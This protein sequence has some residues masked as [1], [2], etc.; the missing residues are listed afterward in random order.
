[1]IHLILGKPG[2]GKTM[3]A[4]RE[5]CNELAKGNRGVVTNMPVRLQPWVNGAGRPM[6]G[7]IEYMRR[8]G[9]EP[10]EVLRRIRLIPDD[11]GGTFYLRR[12][13]Y[14]VQPLHGKDGVSIESFDGSE[15]KD[16]VVYF[17]DECWRFFGARDWA[18][19][20]KALLFYNA[21]HRKFS[22]EVF[23]ITQ[24]W[25]QLETQIRQVV[26]DYWTCRNYGNEVLGYFRRK[27]E[28]CVRV[29]GEPPAASGSFAFSTEKFALDEMIGQT[30]D[31]SGGVGVGASR[32]ADMLQRKKGLPWNLIY[33]GAFGV[34]VLICCVGYF[35]NIGF[36]R[37]LSKSPESAVVVVSPA[38]VLAASPG[39]AVVPSV[40]PLE[41]QASEPPVAPVVLSPQA[42]FNSAARSRGLPPLPVDRS[43]Y[44]TGL[45]GVGKKIHILL[46]DGRSFESRDPEVQ[47][48]NDKFVV[49]LGTVYVWPRKPIFDH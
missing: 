31:T 16:S 8:K 23:F 17:I 49:I 19:T 11:E 4:M 21:Q 10:D 27:K 7:L 24:N 41:F 48:L 38:A 9:V 2:G 6:I 1:M 29:Y 25:K 13:G 3:V 22:D 32:P 14:D 20:S 33:C 15:L 47:L 45:F 39:V 12:L 44:L 42:V 28:I 35:G 18:K 37:L 34:L 43:V 36:R 46:S 26:H 30:Y 5:L 40:S